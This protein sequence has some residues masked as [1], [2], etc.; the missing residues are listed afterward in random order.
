V[1]ARRGAKLRAGQRVALDSR[2]VRLA[3]AT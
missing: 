2:T 3:A 1:E